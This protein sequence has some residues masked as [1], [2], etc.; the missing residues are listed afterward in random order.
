[1]ARTKRKTPA[2]AALPSSPSSEELPVAALR[3]KL[4]EKKKTPE[5]ESTSVSSDP[6]KVVEPAVT[7]PEKKKGRK[8]CRIDTQRK[9]GVAKSSGSVVD[10]ALLDCKFIKWDNFDQVNF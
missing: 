4:K 2:A 1:M 9:K 3:K 7:A 5:T 8:M 10:K 6:S